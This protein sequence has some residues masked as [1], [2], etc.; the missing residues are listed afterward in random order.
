MGYILPYG[1]RDH[2]HANVH[3]CMVRMRNARALAIATALTSTSAVAGFAD[4]YTPKFMI[5]IT[6]KK[7]VTR[8]RGSSRDRPTIRSLF[9]LYSAV[10]GL[11]LAKFSFGGLVDH[12]NHREFGRALC[13][14]H[15]ST[16]TGVS[17]T[18]MF[19]ASC[20]RATGI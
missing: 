12:K 5:M 17:I 6:K 18:L 4:T 11:E 7:I 10:D 13:K 8:G 19:D 14:F 15:S 3:I 16:V 9:Q 20:V 1:G 2:A